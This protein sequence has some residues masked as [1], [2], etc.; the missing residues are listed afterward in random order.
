M[1]LSEQ[2][3]TQNKTHSGVAQC[4]SGWPFQQEHDLRDS[5]VCLHRSSNKFAR[6]W[7]GD[8]FHNQPEQG[9]STLYL[10]N[11]GRSG[12][13]EDALNTP[14]ENLAVYPFVQ[15]TLLTKVVQKLK[16]QTCKLILIA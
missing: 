14:W 4:T 8:P 7:R 2:S 16:S 1:L 9:T 5:G 10:S 6:V 13:A 15:T 12:L 11:P 3:D